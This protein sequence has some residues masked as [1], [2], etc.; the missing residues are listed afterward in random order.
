MA[1]VSAPSRH[2]LTLL[3]LLPLAL[4]HLWLAADLGPF[5]LWAM[6]ASAEHSFEFLQLQLSALPRLSMALLTGAA[7]GLSGSLLQQITQNRLVSPMTI[8]A[9]SG[10]W[11]GLVLATLLVPTFAASHGHWAALLGALVAV[12]L[13]LLIAGRS[14]IGGLPLV[15]GGMAMNLLLG[16]LAAGLVLIN[17]Q[18]TQG[19]F[20]W[21][22]GDLA[23]IDWHWVQWL[24]PKLLL[25]VPV[26]ILAPRPLSL[27]QLGGDAAQGRGLALWPVML[28]LFLAA[29]WLCSVSIT[30]VGLIGFI[31][32]LT[33]NL[34]KM[35]GA[36]TARDELFYSA[37]L[38]ALLLLGTDALA[39]LA[40]RL[41]G[42]LVPSGAA[43]ALI[44]AP[45]LLWLARRHLAAEDPRGL[46]LPRGAERFGW[47]SALWVALLA[48]LALTVALGLARGVDG[49]H[50][51]WPS[52]LVWSLRWPR[53]LTAASAG[54]GL[55]ISGLLLQRLLR[56]PLAS[57]DILGLSAGATLA[58]MLALIIFGGA[59]LGAVAP[60]AAFVGSLAVLAVLMLLGRRHH[61]S[62]ALMALLGISLGALLN[63]ALQFVLA[64]G[65]GDSFALLG[66][67]A[68]S[69]YRATPAQALWL[70]V[71]VLLFGALAVLFQRG[72]T[73]IGIGDGVAASRGLNVPRLRLVLLVLVALLCALV[74]SLLGPVAFLGLLAPH[75]AVML[76]ARRVLPQ[77]L[78][79]ASLG[80]VL[81]LLADW[82]GRTLIFP[83]QIP[84][85][86]V[87]SVLCGSYFVYLLIRGRLA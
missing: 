28:V 45:V 77:L 53:V 17:N 30:A 14:G 31:G 41:S 9:S 2:L 83:L 74:T 46:Q 18:Y 80:A 6:L 22:A 40:N 81:M 11:L 21:G 42:Q 3:A 66:W 7:L 12:G 26:L 76:G 27:L 25:A 65:T 59:L 57:P 36:R 48:V 63:A 10:A 15:L 29:L 61:Y 4:L 38:G 44:G 13:V 79:A 58:V 24:W 82:V 56:N 70:T 67:L 1:A 34:A 23:Q 54:A 49:W 37:L 50:L 60:L 87:A 75:I 55:A 35:L 20:V 73:L 68:G 62:P 85:G 71:G 78:L 72:L 43:A 64:K 5:E 39:L 84:V 32:L 19:L 69:T 52:A 33:P 16:A 47:R 8:G 51:Q 86:I